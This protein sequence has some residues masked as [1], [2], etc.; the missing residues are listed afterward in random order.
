MH[1]PKFRNYYKPIGEY[2]FIL[3]PPVGLLGLADYLRQNGRSSEIIHLGVERLKYGEV[4]LEHILAERNPDIVGLDLH[5]HFQAY[6]VIEVA[7]KIKQF[8]PDIAVLLGGF[9][10]TIFAEE[11][12]RTHDCVDF[13][14]RGES[15]APIL[16]LHRQYCSAKAYDQVA[17]LAYRDGGSV[18][19]NPITYVAD[20]AL[21][22]SI[23]FTDFTLMKDYPLFVE[24]FSRYMNITGVSES[25]Q[26]RVLLYN[27]KAYPLFLGRGCLNACAY[28]G[29]GRDAQVSICGRTFLA[30]RSLGAVTA[31][32]EDIQRFGFEMALLSYDP[33]PSTLAES[34]Y[35]T[36]FEQVKKKNIRLAFDIE[37]WNLP[38]REF[39]RA[40]RDMLPSGSVISITLNSASERVRKKNDTFAFDNR[41]L[42]DCLTIMEEEGVT[43]LL[44]FAIGLPFET[45]KDLQAT[46]DYQEYLRNRFQRVKLMTTMVEIEPGSPL[47]N[48]PEAFEVLPRRSTFADYYHYHSLPDRNQFQEAGYDRKG[49][50]KTEEVAEMVTRLSR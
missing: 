47:S 11:I 49:C 29:G 27:Q 3:F 14:I 30:L 21:L 4:N 5:W 35:L 9:T 13:V 31:S 42:E 45:A 40:V 10:A 6:D 28:C 19:L 16:E 8:R 32:L 15:E 36:L 34:F 26:R 33:L 12:L 1:V 43:C 24:S 20:E 39:I 41:S 25:L 44:F 46:A 50:P 7:K 48:H 2:S 38:T 17:N 22:D 18:K 23:S 37:R